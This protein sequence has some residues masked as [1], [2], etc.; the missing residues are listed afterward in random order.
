MP[1]GNTQYLQPK[2]TDVREPGE[3]QAEQAEA[4]G[5]RG[6]TS[7]GAAPAPYS[8]RY[9]LSFGNKNPGTGFLNPLN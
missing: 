3:G 6:A 7:H 5:T 2:H 8:G 9:T 4:V 1:A